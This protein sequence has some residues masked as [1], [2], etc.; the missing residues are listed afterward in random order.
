MSRLLDEQLLSA[1]DVLLEPQLGVLTSRS[2]AELTPFIYSAPMDTVT[3]YE[4]AKALLEEDEVPVICR[5]ISDEEFGN[6]LRSFHATAALFAVGA[7][8]TELQRFVT[9][10]EQVQEHLPESVKINV[11]IDIAHGDS[12][13]AYTAIKFLRDFSFIG[14]IMSG[15]ICTPAAALRSVAAG[16]THL[17]I[18]VG[19]GSVCTTRMMT[20]VGVPQLS[21][22]Y[23][24]HRE[25]VKS[26]KRGHA[27]LIADGGIRYPGD[28]VKYLSAGAD[29]IMM[30]SIFSKAQEA[31]GWETRWPEANPNE[32]ISFPRPNPVPI[33]VKTF[34]GH[35]S[36]EFQIDHRGASNRCPEGT[37]TRE[38][39]WDGQT[40][41][42]ICEK[43]RGGVAS[44]ISYLGLR[45]LADL[46]PQSVQ[47]MKI[48]TS[49]FMES[50]PHNREVND[51]K[52]I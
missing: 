50:M 19:P 40:V 49:T 20:G 31:L 26:G 52:S 2:E 10:V 4:L 9:R 45:S 27:V 6:C 14:D 33:H 11:A 35:A 23:L 51:V 37:S 12:L 39:Q 46:N 15:S 5:E 44:A 38:F 24:I 30:G 42:S 34:R 8:A 18:G 41:F 36:A 16:C 28:A 21:A 48:T 17:R 47:F 29:A 13:I 25:L 7:T 32:V 1:D 43:F 3:G 22:V